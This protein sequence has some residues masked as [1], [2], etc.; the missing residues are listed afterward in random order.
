MLRQFLSMLIYYQH[1][2]KLLHWKVK[3]EL[4]DTYHDIASG[5]YDKLG[6]Y[7]DSI[8]EIGL[9]LGSEPVDLVEAYALLEGD[10]T[11]NFKILKSGEDYNHKDVL[12]NIS[13]MFSDILGY[14][15]SMYET[16]LIKENISIRVK[17]EEIYSWVDIEVQYKNKRRSM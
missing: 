1:N 16:P 9:T 14:I 15:N 3:D 5:Y 7:I 17:L 11:R 12:E 10:K 13:I 6:G 4:F 2:F 8:A